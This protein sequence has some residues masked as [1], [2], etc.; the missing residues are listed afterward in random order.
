MT[1]LVPLRRNRDFVLYQ[2]GQL[3]SRFGSNISNIAYPLLTLALT[4]SAAK[5]GYVGAAEFA[6]LVLLNAPA[7]I[8]ADRFDRRRL[9]IA[10]DVT[11]ATALG[12]LAVAVLTHNTTYWLILVVAF[13]DMSAAYSPGLRNLPRSARSKSKSTWPPGA[14]CTGCEITRTFPA[15]GCSAAGDSSSSAPPS[16][17]TRNVRA[18]RS[19]V[20]SVSAS[21]APSEF[22]TPIRNGMRSPA[23]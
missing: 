13:V 2:S 4:G 16:R 9:M 14:S 8:A 6:P 12:V 23:A 20:G 7:G 3:L 17:R 19:R 22:V 21:A 5:T 1:E 18:D 15:R 11:A 10:A